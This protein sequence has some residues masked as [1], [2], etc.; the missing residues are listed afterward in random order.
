MSQSPPP[1]IWDPRTTLGLRDLTSD[2]CCTGFNAGLNECNYRIDSTQRRVTER[3]LLAMATRQPVDTIDDLPRLA[4]TSLCKIH[5]ANQIQITENV[6]RWTDTIVNL[7]SPA[8]R[9]RV[10]STRSTPT[11]REDDPFCTSPLKRSLPQSFGSPPSANRYTELERMIR[12][13]Q[14]ELDGVRRELTRTTERVKH[15]E[16]QSLSRER[17]NGESHTSRF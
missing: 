17:Q 5:N 8:Y 13:L 4:S 3:L 6:E 11:V 7:P 9:Q 1:P 16:G 2:C 12:G 15:L 14:E 10:E